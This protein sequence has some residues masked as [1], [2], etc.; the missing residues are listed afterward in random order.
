[1]DL[2]G[3]G[4]VVLLRKWS[5]RASDHTTE[6][7]AHLN[8]SRLSK[9]GRVEWGGQVTLGIARQAVGTLVFIIWPAL[10]ASCGPCT[11]SIAPIHR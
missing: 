6:S 10:W 3:E 4:A 5:L 1:M 2:V 8:T 11:P 7:G 9:G